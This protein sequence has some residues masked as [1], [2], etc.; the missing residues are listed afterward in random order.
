M[1]KFLVNT[2]ESVPLEEFEDKKAGMIPVDNKL[3]DVGA[4]YIEALMFDNQNGNWYQSGAFLHPSYIHVGTSND[5]NLGTAG[6]TIATPVEVG[7]GWSA[8]SRL[9][10]KMSSWLAASPLSYKQVGTQVVVKAIFTDAQLFSG[11]D[12]DVEIRELGLGLDDTEPAASPL[13]ES[14]EME[15]AIIARAVSYSLTTISG[16]QYYTDAPIPWSKDTGTNFEVFYTFRV[17]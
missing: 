13:E 10:Y 15:H 11:T 2:G 7:T 1:G 6:P 14:D 9:D 17:Q 12:E 5:T 16:T 3:L 8:G 4:T